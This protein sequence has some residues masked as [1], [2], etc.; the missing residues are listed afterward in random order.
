M[1]RCGPLETDPEPL[2][3]AGVHDRLFDVVL[4]NILQGPLLDLR[5]RLS[6]YVRPGGS[7]ALSGILVEQAPAVV[8][9]YAADFDD[10]NVQQEGH[11]ALVTGVR[12]V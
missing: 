12:R 6:S 1:M 8:E 4:A 5:P 9:A 7:L 11:W 3:A 10:L 2:Q